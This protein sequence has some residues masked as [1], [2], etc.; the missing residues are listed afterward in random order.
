MSFVST[1]PIEPNG[2]DVGDRKQEA[3]KI[4]A[5]KVPA[6]ILMKTKKSVLTVSRWQQP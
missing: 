4:M 6:I 5:G 3:S 1:S 2:S